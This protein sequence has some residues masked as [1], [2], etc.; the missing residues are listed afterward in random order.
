MYSAEEAF[1]TGTFAGQ[2]PVTEV[3]GRRIGSGAR[4]PT[5]QRL[6]QLY[7][8]LCDEQAAAGRAHLHP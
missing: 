2:I 6:Q 7:A 1:V 8:A 5:V 4:G 3:D